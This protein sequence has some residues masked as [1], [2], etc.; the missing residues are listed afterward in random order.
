MLTSIQAN[1]E[2][3]RIKLALTC[4]LMAQQ[5][6]GSDCV[7]LWSKYFITLVVTHAKTGWLTEVEVDL[8][9][10]SKHV[11]G[12]GLVSYVAV[13]Y[14]ARRRERQQRPGRMPLG[15]FLV[16]LVVTCPRLPLGPKK[17]LPVIFVR[18]NFAKLYLDKKTVTCTKENVILDSGPLS[19]HKRH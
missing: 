1:F 11:K 6:F 16:F 18:S 9:Y 12:P 15:L 13:I 14:F 7:T 17:Y 19:L 4:I 10:H 5:L 3:Q 8:Y 2:S